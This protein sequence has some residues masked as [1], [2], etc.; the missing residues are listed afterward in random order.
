MLVCYTTLSPKWA[1]FTAG[2]SPISPREVS[3]SWARPFDAQNKWA[4]WQST[5][6]PRDLADSNRLSPIDYLTLLCCRPS[7]QT[8][9]PPIYDW[10]FL[11]TPCHF[12]L[13]TSLHGY[14]APSFQSLASSEMYESD[15]IPSNYDQKCRRFV[16]LLKAFSRLSD[17]RNHAICPCDQPISRPPMGIPLDSE[18]S[19]SDIS[20]IGTAIEYNTMTL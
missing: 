18:L 10:A 15:H 4:L 20:P 8:S 16:G 14:Q 13:S 2:T 5:V 3:D 11:S 17:S 6:D 9:A 19:R 7:V 12:H 1:K